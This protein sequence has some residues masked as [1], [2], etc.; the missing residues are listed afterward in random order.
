MREDLKK[1]KEKAEQSFNQDSPGPL[2]VRLT[3]LQAALNDPLIQS[4]VS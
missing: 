1:K 2:R 4:L 3:F